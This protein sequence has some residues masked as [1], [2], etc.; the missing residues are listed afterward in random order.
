M[1]TK[2]MINAL[3]NSMFGCQSVRMSVSYDEQK[4]VSEFFEACRR[5]MFMNCTAILHWKSIDGFEPAK[6]IFVH[7]IQKQERLVKMVMKAMVRRHTFINYRDTLQ[8]S[9]DHDTEKCLCENAGKWD[10]RCIREDIRTSKCGGEWGVQGGWK[11]ESIKEEIK[12]Q[13]SIVEGVYRTLEA[14]G[15]DVD[16]REGQKRI[17]TNLGFYR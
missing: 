8:W 15:I 10:E 13:E 6:C 12:K 7:E 16:D 11:L 14:L 1:E 4:P 2:F 3:C 9:I 5:A 17:L